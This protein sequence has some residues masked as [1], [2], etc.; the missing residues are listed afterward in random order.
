MRRFEVLP[1]CPGHVCLH[2]QDPREEAVKSGL[3]VATATDQQW[4]KF[5]CSEWQC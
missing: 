2:Q 3:P 4:V 1:E 5:R